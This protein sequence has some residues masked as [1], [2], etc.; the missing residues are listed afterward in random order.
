AYMQSP[1][2]S[3]LPEFIRERYAATFKS[4]RESAEKV[5]EREEGFRRVSLFLKEFVAQG[6]KIMAGSDSG[7]SMPSGGLTLHEEMALMNEAGLP[8]MQVIQSATS[9]ATEAWGKSKEVGTV[10]AGKRADILILNRNPLD[11]MSATTDIYRVI[12]GG[13][14]VDREGLAKRWD[15][16]EAVIRPMPMQTGGIPNFLVHVPFIHELSPSLISI[17]RK[18]PSELTLTGRNFSKDSLVLINDR[19]VQTKSAKQDELQV[20]IPS[21]LMKK[22]GVYPLVVVQP[23]SGGAVSNTM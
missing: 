4:P 14:I 16:D 20:S 23:G 7:S 22:Q 10:E 9:W 21:E 5:R 2:I 15:G 18:N 8:P 17:K 1:L 13:K 6:G 11:D 12:Q 3:V 19:L